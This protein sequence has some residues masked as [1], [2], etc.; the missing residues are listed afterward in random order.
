MSEGPLGHLQLAPGVCKGVKMR[1]ALLSVDDFGK[2]GQ[3]TMPK[4]SIGTERPHGEARYGPEASPSSV[5]MCGQPSHTVS[6]SHHTFKCAFS[7]ADK[8]GSTVQRA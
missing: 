8:G 4:R 1:Y 6:S 7:S 3:A 2:R 5:N